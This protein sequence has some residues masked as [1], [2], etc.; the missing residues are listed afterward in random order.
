MLVVELCRRG[1]PTATGSRQSRHPPEPRVR[2]H[3]HLKGLP[4]RLAEPL[5][6]QPSCFFLHARLLVGG[7]GSRPF[8]GAPRPALSSCRRWR[9]AAI[10]LLIASGLCR[11]PGS[12]RD[13]FL[14][15]KTS[16]VYPAASS[17]GSTVHSRSC[18]S[19]H[20]FRAQRAGGNFTGFAIHE[21]MRWFYKT[22]RPALLQ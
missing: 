18:Q 19:L 4:K 11:N 5:P 22:F 7:P 13:V 20:P 3:H 6:A 10:I 12:S 21:I 1:S 15:C 14:R 8:S 17:R 16:P 9:C 2:P